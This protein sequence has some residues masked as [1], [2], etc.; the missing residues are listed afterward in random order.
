MPEQRTPTGPPPATE[1]A[2]GKYLRE[3]SPGGPKAPVVR[4]ER[5]IRPKQARRGSTTPQLLQAM[6]EP[7][8]LCGA[9]PTTTDLGWRCS[10][11]AREQAC[12]DCRAKWEEARDA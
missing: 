10:R 2:F 12:P 3:R 9:P 5:H 6:Q 4:A 11:E 8:T 7:M 1:S